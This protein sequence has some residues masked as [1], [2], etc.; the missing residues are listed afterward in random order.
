[1]DERVA[2]ARL[3]AEPARNV[4]LPIATATAT[5]LDTD[6]V[7]PIELDQPDETDETDEP[8]VVTPPR[9]ERRSSSRRGWRWSRRDRSVAIVVAVGLLILVPIGL[10]LLSKVDTAT[11]KGTVTEIGAIAGLRPAA[12]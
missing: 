11:P 1:M 6:V 10:L 3:G 12:E 9:P 5:A 2:E 8:L 4:T 7:E